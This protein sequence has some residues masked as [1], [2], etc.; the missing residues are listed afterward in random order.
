MVQAQKMLEKNRPVEERKE[1]TTRKIG[2]SWHDEKE[3]PDRL[4]LFYL[5]RFNKQSAKEE[6]KL[7]GTHAL[8]NPEQLTAWYFDIHVTIIQIS[9]KKTVA[10]HED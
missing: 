10:V 3:A 5:Q 7:N 4:A 1:L 2:N 9:A 6:Q 8:P